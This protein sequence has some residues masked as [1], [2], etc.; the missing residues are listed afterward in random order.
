MVH[1]V[2][3]FAPRNLA[4]WPKVDHENPDWIRDVAWLDARGENYTDGGMDPHMDM[5]APHSH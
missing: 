4:D 2:Y 1:I 5:S 3:L